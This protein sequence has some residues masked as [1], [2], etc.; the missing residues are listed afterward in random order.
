ML[1]FQNVLVFVYFILKGY[2]V[3]YLK[4]KFDVQLQPTFFVLNKEWHCVLVLNL[5]GML[6]DIQKCLY[7]LL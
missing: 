6:M 7:V 2:F 5:I 4:S 3:Y 1:L